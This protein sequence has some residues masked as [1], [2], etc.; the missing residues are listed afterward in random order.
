MA[1]TAEQ[2]E[3]YGLSISDATSANHD[4]GIVSVGDKFYSIDDFERQQNEGL[5]T[6]Q[7]GAFDSSLY[8]DAQAK[9]FKV[10]NFNTAT[11]VEGALQALGGVKEEPKPEEP[12]GPIV[13]SP[14]LAHSRAIVA[15]ANDDLISGQAAEDL[16]GVN[17]D[18]ANTFM[19]RYKLRLGERLATGYYVKP[20]QQVTNNSKP[21]SGANGTSMDAAYYAKTGKDN[22]K[23]DDFD[24]VVAQ[25]L[26]QN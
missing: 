19:N 26:I 24:P 17:D 16:Y 9:G 25:G 15:Q 11:D 13:Q 5:D 21:G 20:N 6:D 4:K 3:K 18:P 8:K 1:L 10:K 14:R 12:D 23:L 2:L 7:G 22:R